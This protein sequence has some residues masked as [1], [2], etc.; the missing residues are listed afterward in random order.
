VGGLRE[1]TIETRLNG[2][3]T[4]KVVYRTVVSGSLYQML[5]ITAPNNSHPS[6]ILNNPLPQLSTSLHSFAQNRERAF[7][8]IHMWII[9][10]IRSSL[11]HFRCDA[12]VSDIAWIVWFAQSHWQV[13]TSSMQ[14]K[15]KQSTS[16]KA[17]SRDEAA[18][19][20]WYT[21]TRQGTLS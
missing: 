1:K 15:V 14:Y 11:L 7:E 5:K 12:L 13:K 16:Y 21:N 19:H 20:L 9:L 17:M 10:W 6:R 18:R 4:K 8:I 2:G 3:S